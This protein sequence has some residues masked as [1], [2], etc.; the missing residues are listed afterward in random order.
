[1]EEFIGLIL[2]MSIFSVIIYLIVIGAILLIPIIAILIVVY[3]IKESKKGQQAGQPVKHENK[4]YKNVIE[5]DD[6]EH[7]I[8]DDE[9]FKEIK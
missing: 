5:G 3:L 1:M 6:V 4:L 9:D 8:V 7:E 2:T